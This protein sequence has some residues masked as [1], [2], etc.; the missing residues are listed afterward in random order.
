MNLEADSSL[1]IL[2]ILYAGLNIHPWR[3][4]KYRKKY[5]DVFI[6]IAAERTV[7]WYQRDDD[8]TGF[9]TALDKWK[10]WKDFE[11]TENLIHRMQKKVEAIS[12]H[13]QDLIQKDRDRNVMI[14]FDG[15]PQGTPYGNFVDIAMS[16]R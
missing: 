16:Y 5:S 10:T 4:K 15:D 7:M 12:R 9:V 13:Q 1:E 6:A 2:R 3:M 11:P 8:E 14:D